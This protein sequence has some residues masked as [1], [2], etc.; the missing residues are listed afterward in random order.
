MTKYIKLKSKDS[1]I[2]VVF[3]YENKADLELTRYKK[4]FNVEFLSY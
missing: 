4:N 2:V 3:A 1:E